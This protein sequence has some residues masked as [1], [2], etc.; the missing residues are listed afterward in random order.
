MPYALFSAYYVHVKF[1][2]VTW[3]NYVMLMWAE[4]L[5]G[6]QFPLGQV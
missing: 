3:Y 2:A 6:D 4:Q 1:V 5:T